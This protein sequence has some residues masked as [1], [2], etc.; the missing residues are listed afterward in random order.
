MGTL[1]FTAK[2]GVP[3]AKQFAKMLRFALVVL[4]GAAAH[5]SHAEPESPV[6]PILCAC[7]KVLSPVCGR[8]NETYGNSCE[9]RCHGAGIGCRGVCPC[10]VPT[11]TE[12]FRPV[13]GEDNTNYP[14]ECVAKFEGVEVECEGEC[15]CNCDCSK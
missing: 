7:P 2:A 12:E 15:P 5:V 11:C 1:G 3:L 6:R 8:D 14:N 10:L 9:A 4:F 13:C